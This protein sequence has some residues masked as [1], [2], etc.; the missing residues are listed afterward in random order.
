MSR[1]RLNQP[2]YSYHV[3]GQARVTL[4][5]KTIYLG[6]YDSPESHARY[7]GVLA[8][9]N[10]NGQRLADNTT[11]R[12]DNTPITVS[13][14]VAEYREFIK[15]RPKEKSRFKSLLAVLEY[16]YGG[17]PAAEF[18]PRKLVE[19]R[20]LFVADDNCRR[21][22]NT[23]TRH[24]IRIFRHAVSRELID[25][26]VVTRLATLEPL[27]RGT[28][29][30]SK[31]RQPADLDAVRA[32]IPQLLPVVRAMVRVQIS[33]AMRPGELFRMMPSDIDRSGKVWMYRPT[34]HKTAHHD[35]NKAV[36]IL[37]DAR[38]ALTPYLFGDGHCFLNSVGTPWNKD[39]YRFSVQRACD[40][41]NVKR[42]TPYQLR[43]TAAQ[44][45]RDKLGAEA[46]QA[47]LGHSRMDMTE[48]YAKASEARAIE[49]A[50]VT[51]KLG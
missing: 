13:Q 6:P 34:E 22:C 30:E 39:T 25:V 51:P 4:D 7:Y 38:E 42:W 36:P 32:T 43:R 45:V 11:E 27:A 31:P 12:L 9:Y 19:L 50:K 21:Y 17:D 46:A 24:I 35:I 18:G 23:Q 8:E 28:A 15:D 48:V 10:A 37:G 41:A 44:V 40:R 5:G 33:T 1:K 14:V 26:A 16:E 3:S 47:L 20:S 29:R 2:K 49:A